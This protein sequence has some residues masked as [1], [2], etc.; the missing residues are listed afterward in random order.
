M[1]FDVVHAAIDNRYAD[2]KDIRLVKL[3]W[4]ALFNKYMLTISSGKRLEDISFAHIVS[5][6]YKLKTSAKD[7]DNLSIGF[8]WDRNRKQRELTNKKNQKGQYH[9]W[10]DLKDI[11]GF[12]EHQQKTKNIRIRL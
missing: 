5:L 2:I 10:I 9:N 11:F 12:A 4:I 1:N 6:M 3:G 8:D 7:T